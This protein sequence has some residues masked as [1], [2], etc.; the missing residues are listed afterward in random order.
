MP[1]SFLLTHATEKQFAKFKNDAIAKNE[2]AEFEDWVEEEH[3]QCL[4]REA[5]EAAAKGD[6][7]RA[8]D[9]MTSLWIYPV[10]KRMYDCTSEELNIG[11]EYDKRREA[12]K[13]N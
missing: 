6:N 9:L 12:K 2:E 5:D 4:R 7:V 8:V 3:N 13:A 10:G 1:K 11:I